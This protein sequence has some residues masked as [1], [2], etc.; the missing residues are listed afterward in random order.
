[1]R[2]L[3][4]FVDVAFDA[5]DKPFQLRQ[6][7]EIVVAVHFQFTEFRPEGLIAR[8]RAGKH[9]WRRP[10][11]PWSGAAV[12]ADAVELIFL[13][14]LRDLAL[15]PFLRK[16]QRVDELFE[17]RYAA[18]HARTVNDQLTDRVHHAVEPCKRDANR[19]CC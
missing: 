5:P 18:H 14:K 10:R 17:F 4:E 16:T 8:S 1:M 19:F 7:I 2:Q 9:P 12:R 11:A 13:L 6:N 15:Q 3:R